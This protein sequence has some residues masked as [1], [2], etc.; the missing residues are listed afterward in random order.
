MTGTAGRPPGRRTWVEQ[1]MGMPISVHVR[2]GADALFVAD[3]V[4]EAYGSLRQVDRIFSLYRVDSQLSEL[5]QGVRALT[6]CDP[7][8]REVL[9]LCEQARELTD[10]WFDALLPGRD[11]RAAFDPSG[12]VKGWAAERAAA[13]LADRGVADFSLNAGGD[14]VLCGGNGLPPWRVGVEDPAEPDRLWAVLE[15]GEAAVATS[16]TARRG[17]HIVNP[18]SGRAVAGLVSVTVLGPSLT[19][20]DVY[21]TAAVAR[22]PDNLAW[23]GGHPGYHALVVDGNGLVAATPGIPTALS[24]S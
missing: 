1:V 23:L 22:G 17:A 3:A 12:L 19:W 9:D 2:S 13:L 7:L 5:N 16:G 11:G 24:A 20:A 14:I 21:A 6:D 8:V 10:G 15:V 4:A 18:R